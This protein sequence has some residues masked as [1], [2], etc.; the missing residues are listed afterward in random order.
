MK[1]LNR[2][3]FERLCKEKYPKL[4]K[5]DAIARMKKDWQVVV[6]NRQTSSKKS[7]YVCESFLK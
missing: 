3:E 6:T 4:K 2:L 1:K 5:Q 7:Y